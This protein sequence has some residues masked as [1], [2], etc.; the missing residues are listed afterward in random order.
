MTAR[1]LARIG[2]VWAQFGAYHIDRCEAVGHHFENVADDRAEVWAIEVASASHVYAWEPSADLHHARKVTLFPGQVY[3]EIG[4]HRRFMALLRSV[5]SCDIVFFGIGYNE[6]YIIAIAWLLRMSG[7]RVIMMSDSKFDDSARSVWFE[8][9]KSVVLAVFQ[10]GLVAGSAQ[11]DYLRFLGFRRRPVLDGYDCISNARIQAQAGDCGAVPFEQRQ[12]ICVARHV[13]KKNLFTL[14]DAYALYLNHAPAMPR[15]LQLVG[16]GP[17][18]Q[19][20]RE[21]CA[22]NGIAHMVDI[23]GFQTMPT[24]ARM[25]A[26]SLALVLVST[27]EQWGLVVNEA[28]AL[29]L[30]LIISDRVGA[31]ERLARNLV[32][33]YVVPPRDQEAI[34]QA[35]VC[36]GEDAAQW[37]RMSLQSQA[38]AAEGNICKF[39]YSVERMVDM[40][41][42]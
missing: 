7:R 12:F 27:E 13:P 14:L 23:T 32:N 36:M 6:L 15:R 34:A 20:L 3:E 21:H 5:W 31:G 40:T 25:M 22:Q 29:G 38:I 16:G 26:G 28:V 2:L 9:V 39:V 4:L 33:G 1:R 37:E 41:M 35:M 11:K 17:Q 10:G 19:A 30:P 24:V 8:A 42:P 18:E